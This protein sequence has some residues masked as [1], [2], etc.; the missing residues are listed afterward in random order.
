MAHTI[1]V[2]ANGIGED[3]IFWEC[4]DE[5]DMLSRERSQGRGI[6]AGSETVEYHLDLS[7]ECV[8]G[9]IQSC[10]VEY[11]FGHG[12]SEKDDRV[13]MNENIRA[14]STKSSID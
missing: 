10:T 5:L 14:T 3:D 6:G 9:Y 2:R 13:R 12:T 11:V 7:V 8:N 1:L 4:D